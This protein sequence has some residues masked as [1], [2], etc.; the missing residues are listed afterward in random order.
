M[1]G[2]G[3]CSFK[4]TSTSQFWRDD[5]SRIW[6]LWQPVS[7]QT[8]AIA[9]ATNTPVRKLNSFRTVHNKILGSN[10]YASRHQVEKVEKNILT[11]NRDDWDSEYHDLYIHKTGNNVNEKKKSCKKW[12]LSRWFEIWWLMLTQ[13]WQGDTLYY[14]MTHSPTIFIEGICSVIK[15]IKL[16]LAAMEISRVLDISRPPGKFQGG[17][18]LRSDTLWQPVCLTIEMKNCSECEK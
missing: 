2:A 4:V 1:G 5:G 18:Y 9:A 7:E 3:V 13:C 15:M 12:K 14:C 8:A 10:P 6:Q 16:W 17:P 11:I